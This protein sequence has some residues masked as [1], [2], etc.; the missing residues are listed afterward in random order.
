RIGNVIRFDLRRS[1]EE[2]IQLSEHVDI[3]TTVVG[4]R[5]LP[6][7]PKADSY[8]FHSAWGNE[9]DLITEPL[10]FAEY[11]KPTRKDA[12]RMLWIVHAALI[13]AI[14]TRPLVGIQ[15]PSTIADGTPVRIR[16]NPD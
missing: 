11:R 15:A 9:R 16:I 10:P 13:A 1:F 14:V 4:V 2:L 12:H 3:T 5:L 8:R 6:R 7:I